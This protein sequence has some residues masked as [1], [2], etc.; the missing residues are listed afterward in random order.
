[1]LRNPVPLIMFERLEGLVRIPYGQARF[2]PNNQPNDNIWFWI[3]M[4]AIDALS[5]VTLQQ[6]YYLLASD[7]SGAFDYPIAYDWQFNIPNNHFQYAIT[8]FCFALITFVMCII[9]QR[10]YIFERRAAKSPRKKPAKN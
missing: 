3:D 9:Y 7:N 8:W 4:K 2:V 10:K 5:G 6:D 1:M